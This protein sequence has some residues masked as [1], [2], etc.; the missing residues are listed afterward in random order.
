M[1]SA[2]FHPASRDRAGEY[3]ERAQKWIPERVT[4]GISQTLPKTLE[5]LR[6]LGLGSRIITLM[7]TG[8]GWVYAL[9]RSHLRECMLDA[10]SIKIVTGAASSCETC[11]RRWISLV[12]QRTLL[13]LGRGA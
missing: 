13:V 2:E 7:E 9:S 3:G 8:L 11:T 5:R 12:H 4:Q 1:F 10:V 6:R